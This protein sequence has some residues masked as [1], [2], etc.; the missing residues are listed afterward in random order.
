MK[1]WG[2]SLDKKPPIVIV[3]DKELPGALGLYD[4]CENIVYYIE[5]VGKKNIQDSAGGFGE[6]EFHEMWHLK[7]A[8]EYRSS[9]KTITRENRNQYFESLTQKCKKRIDKLGI[10]GLNVKEL[11]DY[12]WEC[13]FNKRYDEV[14]AEYMALR[15]RKV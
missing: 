9:G 6:I 13:Y 1:Q 7:Q 4:A 2:I 5:G 10:T 3:G 14:E 11:S 12:A 15:K 8:E